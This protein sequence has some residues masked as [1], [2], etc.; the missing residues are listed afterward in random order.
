M[1]LGA[2]DG[3]GLNLRFN[4]TFQRSYSSD[5]LGI[6][7]IQAFAIAGLTRVRV[8]FGPMLTNH[9]NSFLQVGECC[10]GDQAFAFANLTCSR[11]PF[12]PMITNHAN[13][14]LQVASSALV[15]K[16]L[17]WES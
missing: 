7:S 6:I 5:E 8:P 13:Y 3:T 14:F 10:L 17:L 1:L 4:I 9:A 16:L 11:L 2:C 12:C 15:R